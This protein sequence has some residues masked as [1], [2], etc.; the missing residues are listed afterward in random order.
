[1]RRSSGLNI[2][3]ERGTSYLEFLLLLLLVVF[4]LSQAVLLFLDGLKLRATL[5]KLVLLYPFP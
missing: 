5:V 4:P 2:K 3:G 1:M